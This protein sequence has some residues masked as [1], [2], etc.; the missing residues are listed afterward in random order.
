MQDNG[1][2][3]DD[4]EEPEVADSV[5]VCFH[6]ISTEVHGSQI[7]HC[8]SIND[9]DLRVPEV[10]QLV[11]PDLPNNLCHQIEA[12]NINQHQV[13]QVRG[14]QSNDFDNQW[15]TPWYRRELNDH[16]QVH[17]NKQG[18]IQLSLLIVDTYS[19]RIIMFIESQKFIHIIIFAQKHKEHEV[20]NVEKHHHEIPNE[21]E[22]MATGGFVKMLPEEDE[23]VD[24]LFSKI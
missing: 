3:D 7:E 18:I 4:C 11:A 2:Q 9:R 5:L 21:F 1:E 14:S 20:G 16:E 17:H 8:Q 12:E 24:L 10:W 23:I 15:H 13:K 22:I 19:M 6:E